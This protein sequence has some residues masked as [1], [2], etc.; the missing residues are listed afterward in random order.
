MKKI[1]FILVSFLIFFSPLYSS[2]K[3]ELNVEIKETIKEFKKQVKG[4]NQLLNKAKGVLIFP[5]VYKAGF[6]IGGEYGEGVFL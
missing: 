3:Y 6:G 2:S 5:N 1:I 4:A